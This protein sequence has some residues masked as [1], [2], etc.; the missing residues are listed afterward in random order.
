MSDLQNN[1]QMGWIGCSYYVAITI[2]LFVGVFFAFFAFS[3]HYDCVELPNGFL[4]GNSAVFSNNYNG[5]IDIALKLPNG[6]VLLRRSLRGDRDI[7]YIDEKIIMTS[8]RDEHK[9]RNKGFM[10]VKDIGLVTK[11]DQ[12]EFFKKYHTKVKRKLAAKKFKL[13]NL[14]G[15]Y[16]GLWQP[17]DPSSI[18]IFPMM[19]KNQMT[20]TGEAGAQRLGLSQRWLT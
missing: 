14:Y 10:Y 6:K 18:D 9:D 19:T 15:V 17:D 11:M 4:V 3:S 7:Y 16:W 5:Y 13:T 12:P 1:N 2:T 20:I 8:M